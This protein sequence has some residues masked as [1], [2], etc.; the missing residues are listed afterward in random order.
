MSLTL[1]P[2]YVSLSFMTIP[3]AVNIP[4]ASGPYD[5][6]RDRGGAAARAAEAARAQQVRLL[7]R[8]AEVGMEFARAA[9]GRVIEAAGA[10]ESADIGDR[11]IAFA[12]VARAIRQTIGLEVKLRAERRAEDCDPAADTATRRQLRLLQELAQISFAVAETPANP[13]A[14]PIF[15]RV[16]RAV[17]QIIGAATNL[18]SGRGAP[19]PGGKPAAPPAPAEPAANPTEDESEEEPVGGGGDIASTLGETLDAFNEYY[20]FLRMPID[21]AVALIF[22]TLGVPVESGS[23]PTE[24]A[25]EPD[26]ASAPA[27]GLTGDGAAPASERERPPARLEPDRPG[28][29]NRGPP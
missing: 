27:P 5:P 14:V 3:P 26:P 2:W 17:R 8:L 7:E 20:R 29:G 21:Q 24:G 22:K 19:G 12:K 16:A 11:A 10:E 9:A 25:D 23:A 13:V 1:W 18:R 4:V 15:L 28:A 6:V